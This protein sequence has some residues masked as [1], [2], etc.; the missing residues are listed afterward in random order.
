MRGPN[1][2]KRK[3]VAVSNAASRRASV[4][5]YTSSASDDTSSSSVGI[6]SVFEPSPQSSLDATASSSSAPSPESFSSPEVKKE[7]LE[8]SR[9]QRLR[10]P[11]LNFKETE[12][13]RTFVHN[14]DSS[15]ENALDDETVVAFRRSS[16]PSYLLD[17][18][19]R[20]V[21][22]PQLG[23]TRRSYSTQPFAFGKSSFSTFP[24]KGPHAVHHS[25]STPITPI[26]VTAP[27]ALHRP[28][29]QPAH[30]V[31]PSYIPSVDPHEA[32]MTAAESHYGVPPSDTS[33]GLAWAESMM[34]L[35][36]TPTAECS[37][38][39]KSLAQIGSQMVV[40][41]A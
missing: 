4:V 9:L 7:P 3:S 32:H 23:P 27:N 30:F 2:V 11:S 28:I 20:D 10:P 18:F 26:T 33:S 14:P 29:A 24:P 34:D 41:Q 16:L 25:S 8:E 17:N 1:K 15:Q 13:L 38:R 31:P 40:S 21:S 5:S 37:S 6:P 36:P 12:S 19:S 22:R 39:E 35:D